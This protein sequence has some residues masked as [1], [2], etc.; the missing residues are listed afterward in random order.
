MPPSADDDSYSTLRPDEPVRGRQSAPLP[1]ESTEDGSTLR[2]GGAAAPPPPERFDTDR[3]DTV[4]DPDE[5]AQASDASRQETNVGITQSELMETMRKSVEVGRE[6]GDYEILE[7]IDRGGMGVVVRARQKKL[8]RIVAVKLIISGA[9]ADD[10][11]VQRFYTE[12]EAAAD[13]DHPNI[14]PIYE[15]GVVDGLHFYSMRFID[16]PSLAHQVA[17]GP[18]EAGEAAR[19]TRAVADGV[20]YA[21]QRGILHRDLKPANILLD[22]GEVP[23]IMDFGLAKRMDDDQGLTGTGQVLGTPGFMP[24]EQ[25]LGNIREIA[26]ASDIYSLGAILYCLLT[27]R[28]PFQAASIME[29]LNQVIK[30]EPVPPRQ[31]NASVPEDLETICLKCLSKEKSHRYDS[32]EALADDLTRYLEGHS[33]HARP[34]GRLRRF[35]RWCRRNPVVAALSITAATSLIVGTVASTMFAIAAAE[36]AR[37]AEAHLLES[38][39]QYA[40]AESNFKL[41]RS[42]VDE[43]FTQVSDNTLLNQ[44]GMQPLQQDLLRQALSYYEQFL[45]D[46]AD[47]PE[48]QDDLAG[49]SFRVGLINETVEADPARAAVPLETAKEIQERLVEETPDDV[50]R[51]SALADTLTA[52]GRVRFRST[53]PESATKI[54]RQ[55]L[56]IRQT[57]AAAAPD[58]ELR[59]VVASSHMNLGLVS[60]NLGDIP[61]ARKQFLQAQ[62]IRSSLLAEEQDD[63]VLRDLAMGHYNLGNLALNDPDAAEAEALGHFESAISVF[64]DVVKAEPID[65]ANQSRLALCYRILGDL[66]SGGDQLEA[67]RAAYQQSGQTLRELVRL[68]PGVPQYREQ[69]TSLQMNLGHL[70][71]STGDS[72]AAAAAFEEALELVTVLRSEHA[73]MDNERN[74]AI[75][76][77]ELALLEAEQGKAAESQRRFDDAEAV[78]KALIDKNPDDDQLPLDLQD[79]IN[80]RSE[81]NVDR[82]DQ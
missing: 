46:H 72:E 55:A 76:Q 10:A 58:R 80:L 73:S 11:D 26:P 7:E 23:L 13:L 79:T 50:D 6:L 24:P 14:V 51:R 1:E 82:G 31:L 68:N 34:I 78:L 54:L 49:A 71:V 66:E 75:S 56:E 39:K 29:T 28:A 60:M 33:V 27:G 40:R 81:L 70:L 38:Q 67:A 47:E 15:I 37:E 42:A 19:L 74:Y 52:L 12:A 30:N 57:L 35:G 48:V 20:G 64:E 65:L 4:V 59:R 9:L 63:E 62:E 36:R 61:E 53:G 21:H 8:N 2:G 17:D 43:F 44:P 41:A 18:L 32:A 5:E 3:H 45:V 77:R 69:L 25:A 22:A 16:G